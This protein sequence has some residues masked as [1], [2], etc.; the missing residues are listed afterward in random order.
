MGPR[1]YFGEIGLLRG[2]PRTATIR[3]VEPC[4][5]WK[6]S[7]EEF[8]DALAMSTPSASLLDVSTRRLARTHPQLVTE[9]VQETETV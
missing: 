8:L 4:V 9:P 1:S 5:L 6:L 3:T 7:G 2:I